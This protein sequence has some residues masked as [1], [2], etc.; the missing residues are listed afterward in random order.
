MM[1]YLTNTGAVRSQNSENE[2]MR[3]MRYCSKYS[4]WMYLLYVL[5]QLFL[6]HVRKWHCWIFKILS[7]YLSVFELERPGWKPTLALIWRQFTP[8]FNNYF[9]AVKHNLITIKLLSI[10]VWKYAERVCLQITNQT[11]STFL[12]IL[13][14]NDTTSHN[15]FFWSTPV[16]WKFICLT[17]TLRHWSPYGMLH[18]EDPLYTKYTFTRYWYSSALISMLKT[19]CI[20][21]MGEQPLPYPFLKEYQVYVVPL[22]LK[23]NLYLAGRGAGILPDQLS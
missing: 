6:E 19:K 21:I 2:I 4:F 5:P 15:T 16:S 18:P 7:I 3:I 11:I 20:Q 9:L 1:L 17:T 13:K 10:C 12:C 22:C 8:I 23:P 14:V